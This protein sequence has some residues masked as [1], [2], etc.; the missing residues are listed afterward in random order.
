MLT[1][2]PQLKKALSDLKQSVQES[3][4]HGKNLKK[5][6]IESTLG[7]KLEKHAQLELVLDKYLELI[8]KQLVPALVKVIEPEPAHEPQNSGGKRRGLP[9]YR[10]RLPMHYSLP[11]QKVKPRHAYSRDIGAMGL[12]I[13]SNRLEKVGQSL[14]VDIE[15][16]EYGLIKVQAVVVWTKWVPPP[17]RSVEYTGFGVRIT[18][19]PQKWYEFFLSVEEEHHSHGGDHGYHH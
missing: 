14:Q 7:T 15:V 19:A 6:L 8:E 3:M 11:G 1:K 12:F 5:S 4:S 2:T 10:R 13:M 18:Y 9:R 16:P 17:L